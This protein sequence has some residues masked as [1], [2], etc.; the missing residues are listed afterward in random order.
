MKNYRF[1][2]DG[3]GL[4]DFFFGVMF[5]EYDGYY[6]LYGR[7]VINKILKKVNDSGISYMV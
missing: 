6:R 2:E 4:V 3:S 7:G 5:K 1:L